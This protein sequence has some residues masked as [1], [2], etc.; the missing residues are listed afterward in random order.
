ME[1]RNK[2]M[3]EDFLDKRYEAAFKI[4]TSLTKNFT[5]MRPFIGL[6]KEFAGYAIEYGEEVISYVMNTQKMFYDKRMLPFEV[7]SSA[8]RYKIDKL[9]LGDTRDFLLYVWLAYKHVEEDWYWDE[10]LHQYVSRNNFWSKE[11]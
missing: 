5:D 6:M 7:K 1:H 4:R 10:R 8:D 9:P 3:R 2:D 11:L